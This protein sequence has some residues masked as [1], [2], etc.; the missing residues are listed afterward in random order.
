MDN[1]RTAARASL[2]ERTWPDRD[3][4]Y[5]PAGRL[6]MGTDPE[7]SVTDPGGRVHGLENLFVSETA[8]VATIGSTSPTPTM[9][10]LAIRVARS[11]RERG[12]RGEP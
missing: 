7:T 2:P 9:V 1:P 6:R 5:R 3:S 10:A 4:C 11:I 12:G 8:L